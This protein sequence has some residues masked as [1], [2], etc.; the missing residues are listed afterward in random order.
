MTSEGNS[1]LLPAN[2]DLSLIFTFHKFAQVKF[3]VDYV[4]KHLV[5]G[6]SGNLLNLLPSKVEVCHGYAPGNIKILEKKNIN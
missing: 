6:H 2:I 3:F 1:V 4:S 5:T